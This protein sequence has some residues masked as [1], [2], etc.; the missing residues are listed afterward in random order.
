MALTIE[1]PDVERL[2]DEL[3]RKTG[4][5]TAE[6]VGNALRDRLARITEQQGN[7]PHVRNL[8]E[9]IRHFNSLPVLDDRT[10]DEILGYDENGLPA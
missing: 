8:E 2:A 6:A 9:I 10:D 1:D 3:S 7:R 4:E 5:T